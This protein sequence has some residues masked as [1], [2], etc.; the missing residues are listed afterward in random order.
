MASQCITLT[1][2]LAAPRAK[3][4]SILF[5]SHTRG[6]SRAA[7]AVRSSAQTKISSTLAGRRNDPLVAVIDSCSRC[8]LEASG[9]SAAAKAKDLGSAMGDHEQDQPGGD[10]DSGEAGSTSP[11]QAYLERSF[12]AV[13]RSATSSAHDGREAAEEGM[14]K[15]AGLVV[16]AYSGNE[17][18][19][20]DSICSAIG[21][22]F[23]EDSLQAVVGVGDGSQPRVQHVPGKIRF[24]V[25]SFRKIHQ[26][27]CSNMYIC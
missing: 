6:L 19:D 20:A 13:T 23:L 14:A 15:G 22:A 7:F 4:G 17:A 18:C 24:N 26:H 27:N 21:A 9:Q 2:V 3:P 11:L 25:D 16:H 5:F 1:L 8:R 10:G 12:T